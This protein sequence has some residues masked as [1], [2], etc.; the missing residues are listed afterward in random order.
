MIDCF[1]NA[2]KWSPPLF[3]LYTKGREFSKV[4]HIHLPDYSPM[5]CPKVLGIFT[6]AFEDVPNKAKKENYKYNIED[7]LLNYTPY[8]V[9]YKS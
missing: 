4:S 7:A 8:F 1:H 9:K 3:F 6:M 2:H 5:V